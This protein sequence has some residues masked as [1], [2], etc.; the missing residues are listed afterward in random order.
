M[1]GRSAKFDGRPAA[2]VYAACR[3]VFALTTAV[4]PEACWVPRT[5]PGG[6]PVTAP[7]G[8][9]TPRSPRTMVTGPVAVLPTDAP[10]STANG[11]ALPRSIG[12]TMRGPTADT[13]VDWATTDSPVV[14]TSTTAIAADPNFPAPNFR[15]LHTVVSSSATRRVKFAKSV[16]PQTAARYVATPTL[17][18]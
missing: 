6:K 18:V 8:A 5:R 2:A 14:V 4:A 11:A 10:A 13:G 7:A 15:I 1:S 9:S 3:S 16:H 17:N 12:L